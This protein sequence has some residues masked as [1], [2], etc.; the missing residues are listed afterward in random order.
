MVGVSSDPQ[1]TSDEFRRSLDLPFPLVGDPNAEI[2]SAYDVKWPLVK[3]AH[4]VTYLIRQDRTIGAVHKSARDIDSHVQL[5]C[6]FDP[7]G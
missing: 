4:R 5:A 6:T 7:A 2:I 1:R 3:L